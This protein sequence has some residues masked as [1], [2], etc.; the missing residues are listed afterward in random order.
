MPMLWL[1]DWALLL[2]LARDVASSVAS[3]VCAMLRRKALSHAT[4]SSHVRELGMDFKNKAA[5]QAYVDYLN[6]EKWGPALRRA[7][8]AIARGSLDGWHAW[9]VKASAI[10]S[11]MDRVEALIPGLPA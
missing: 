7:D 2:P 8:V 10:R 11:E 9:N 5:A 6:L 4:F 3:L 1:G